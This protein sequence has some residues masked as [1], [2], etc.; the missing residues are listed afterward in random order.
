MR[1]E[2]SDSAVLP[3]IT[4][5]TLT[6]GTMS[7]ASVGAAPRDFADIQRVL[8]RQLAKM[9][10]VYDSMT[11]AGITQA[12]RAACDSASNVDIAIETRSG[13]YELRIRP[14]RGPGEFVPAVRLWLGPRG[15]PLPALRPAVGT[16]WDLETQTLQ[17]PK[18]ITR[19][20]EM[21]DEEYVPRMSIAEAFRWAF[22]FDRHAEVLDLLYDPQPGAKL[23]VEISLLL[24]SRRPARWRITSR[25]R[26]DGRAREVWSV[27]EDVTSGDVPS[28]SPT[29]EQVGLREAHR[30]AGTYLAVVRPEH[31]S[32]SHW[33]T[34]PAPWIRWDYLFRPVDV[35]HPDDRARLM[36]STAR[37]RTGEAAGIT[38]R[39]LNYR[40]GYSPTSLLLYPYPGQANRL[41]IAQFVQIVDDVAQPESGRDSRWPMNAPIGYDDQLRHCLAGCMCRDL[42]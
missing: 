20:A 13:P 34:D 35:F 15:A 25:A 7:V 36:G 26:T 39:T 4:V 29:L 22:A 30:R 8:Q 31:T 38:V 3:W 5:E 23:Q 17:L 1:S 41:A 11:T 9:P 33:L 27:V 18:A 10:A 16:V 6:P 37:L 42:A 32:I 19:V 14:V 21:T 24:G 2:V 40:G 28:D 12:V